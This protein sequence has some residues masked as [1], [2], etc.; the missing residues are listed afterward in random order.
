MIK[1][2]GEIFDIDDYVFIH[3]DDACCYH[4][5]ISSI[6][7]DDVTVEIDDRSYVI[8]RKNIT[9]IQRSY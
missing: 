9:Y 7:G 2:R 5:Y 8:D 4:G 1:S 6:T 3:T